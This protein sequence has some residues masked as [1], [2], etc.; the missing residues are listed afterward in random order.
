MRKW[1]RQLVAGGLGLDDVRQ[2]FAC[3]YAD[4]GLLV[5]R[6]PEHLQL[7]FDLLTSLFNRVG[8]K[9]NTTKT[10]AMSF[11]PRRIRQGLSDKAYLARIDPEAREATTVQKVQCELCQVDLVVG[12]LALHLETQHNMRHCYLGKAVCPV[13]PP[14]YEAQYMPATGKWLCA[15]PDCPQGQGGAFFPERATFGHQPF[16][17][18]PRGALNIIIVFY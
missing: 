15:V 9:T 18:G 4:D 12:S 7:V 1:E 17:S 13:A 3:F 16:L 2:L 14:S 11:L 10:K 5:V 6:K 8:L